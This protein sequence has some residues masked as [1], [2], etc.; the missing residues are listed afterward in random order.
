MMAAMSAFML[1][2]RSI[3]R[4]SRSVGF[5]VHAAWSHGDSWLAFVTPEHRHGLW[6]RRSGE[7]RWIATEIHYRDC[8]K[9]WDG[10]SDFSV[11]ESLES[12]SAAVSGPPDGYT[13]PPPRWVESVR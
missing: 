7:Y 8:P 11:D 10:V 1:S 5:P 6:H 12:L 4:V 13:A 2:A 9:S 3:R